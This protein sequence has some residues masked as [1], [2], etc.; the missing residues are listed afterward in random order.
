MATR[1]SHSKTFAGV[2]S[3]TRDNKEFGSRGGRIS[4]K[5][6]VTIKTLLELGFSAGKIERMVGVPM[7]TIY[8]LKKGYFGKLDE[9]ES[10]PEM[11]SAWNERRKKFIDTAYDKVEALFTSINEQKIKA[12]DLKMTVD[13]ISKLIDKISLMLGTTRSS[14]EVSEE[15]GLIK[16]MKVDQLDRFINSSISTLGISNGD[17]A[18]ILRRTV[19]HTV[20]GT[21]LSQAEDGEASE[22]SEET[23][24]KEVSNGNNGDGKKPV[25]HPLDPALSVPDGTGTKPVYS[26]EGSDGTEET[27]SAG[28]G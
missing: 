23:D 5:T 27:V 11:K 22:A 13:A 9:V 10:D 19:K 14:T 24:S 25:R 20:E 16:G 26:D 21:P 4:A 17:A 18:V 28:A 12:A 6:K 15:M 7:D 3:L 2:D 1:N 8:K